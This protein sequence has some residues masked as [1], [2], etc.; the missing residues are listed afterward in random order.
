MN[1]A[2]INQR[3]FCGIDPKAN[4]MYVKILDREGQVLYKRNMLNNIA[5]FKKILTP[6]T[7]GHFCWCASIFNYYWIYHGCVESG[8]PFYLGHSAFMKA[9]ARNKK[10]NDLLDAEM[11]AYLMRSNLF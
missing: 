10:K 7:S 8:I 9:I 5:L 4:S 11:I 3:Y 2:Q 1:Y 6:F